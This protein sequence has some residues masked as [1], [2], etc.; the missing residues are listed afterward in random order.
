MDET[1]VKHYRKTQYI[2]LDGMNREMQNAKE[3]R[4]EV[5]RRAGGGRS[6]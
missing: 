2:G 1:T 3:N 4:D 6:R 5:H